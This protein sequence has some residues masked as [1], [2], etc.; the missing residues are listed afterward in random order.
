[1]NNQ[2]TTD[3]V[4]L[5]VLMVGPKHGYEIRQFLDDSL[6]SKWHI[7]SSQ[8]YSLLKRLEGK[9][10]VKS[11]LSVQTKRPSKRVYSLMPKGKEAFLAWIEQPVMHVR[12]LR[13]EFLAKL[14]FI[15]RL[16]LPGGNQVIQKQIDALS[17]I[18]AKIQ[19]AQ[20]L[21]RLPFEKLSLRFRQMTIEAH[22]QWLKTAVVEFIEQNKHY[23]R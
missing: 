23:S 11:F 19:K 14:F 3:Y 13:I 9:Q 20:S 15:D 16:C 7:S 4:L 5:G 12:N 10:L 22:I 1:M 2:R 6:E 8:M 21:E 18:L 17:S